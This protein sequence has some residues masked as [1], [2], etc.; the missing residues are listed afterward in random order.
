MENQMETG[1]EGRKGAPPA[2]GKSTLK[3]H[4]IK[5]TSFRVVH[6]HGCMGAL[7]P[8]GSGLNVGFFSERVPIPQMTVYELNANGTLGDEL[9]EQRI[10]KSG[11]VREM[12]F[13]AF[14]NETDA[15]ALHA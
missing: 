3:F 13:M 14:L 5:S 4:Y 10:S 7:A 9:V 1:E 6:C 2:E 11:V 15:S 12:E 8:D